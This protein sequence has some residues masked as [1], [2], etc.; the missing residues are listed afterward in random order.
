M[1]S[2]PKKAAV[3]AFVRLW[4][5]PDDQASAVDL[6]ALTAHPRKGWDEPTRDSADDGFDVVKFRRSTLA[7]LLADTI[8]A[9][10]AAP[11]DATHGPE[12][13]ILTAVKA[14]LGARYEAGWEKRIEAY[15]KASGWTGVDLEDPT[16]PAPAPSPSPA[17]AANPPS[18]GGQPAAAPG[19]AAPPAQPRLLPGLGAPAP[20]AAAPGAVRALPGQQPA[21]SAAPP[22]AAPSPPPPL[23]VIKGLVVQQFARPAVQR[24][25][26]SL[27]VAFARGDLATVD[28]MRRNL[29]Q[30]VADRV[31]GSDAIGTLRVYIDIRRSPAGMQMTLAELHAAFG[32][33]PP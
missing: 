5:S 9:T 26:A 11:P 21:P 15:A 1:A 25:L 20:V 10:I 29:D 28:T 4:T 24:F 14:A 6:T 7:G 27:L 19:A 12:C 33:N 3:A 18:G 16:A 22:A 17:P 23:I 31:Y 13:Y 32:L 8:D 30:P 2:D